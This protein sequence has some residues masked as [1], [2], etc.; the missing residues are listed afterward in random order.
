MLI[1]CNECG[2]RFSSGEQFNAHY[3]SSYEYDEGVRK[4]RQEYRR[5]LEMGTAYGE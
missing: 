3:C 5:Q 4:W 2:R 1:T